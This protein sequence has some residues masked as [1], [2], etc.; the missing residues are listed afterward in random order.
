MKICFLD[1]TPLGYSYDDLNSANIRGA[2][3][4]IINLAVE[5]AKNNNEIVVFNNIQKEKQIKKVSWKNLKNINS[6]FFFDVAITNNDI[7]LLDKINSH[8]KI[9]FSHSIQTI[10]KFIRKKQLFSYLKNKPII[11]LLG[12]YHNSQ[13][14][15]FLKMFGKK[16]MS[17][18]VDSMIIDQKIPLINNSNNAIF[19]SRPDRNLDIA[20]EVWKNFIFKKNKKYNFFVTPIKENLEKYNIFHRS[21]DDKKLMI[22]DLL[23]SKIC[24][25]PGHKAEL[26]CIAAEEAK[27]LC[28]PIVTLGFGSLS[29]RVDHNKNGLIAKTPQELGKFVIELFEDNVF[30]N[31]LRDN[32]KLERGSKN[33]A[34]ITRNFYNIIK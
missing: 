2:E 31:L 30:Y 33:W 27:E 1:N 12:K 23:K 8:K 7:R 28:I 14:N 19:T 17:W 9:A 6:S 22:T 29:E 25:L 4:A 24:I 18:G 21:F 32:L 16:F 3:N 5:L 34:K 15:F 20:I 11:I 26:Y 10:E 13:R